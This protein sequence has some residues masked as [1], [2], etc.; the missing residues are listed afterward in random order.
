MDDRFVEAVREVDED[1]TSDGLADILWLAAHMADKSRVPRVGRHAKAARRSAGRITTAPAV[2]PP[3]RKPGS[4]AHT[5]K[6][7]PPP[8]HKV[9]DV[10]L[11]R[12]DFRADRPAV[13]AR[14]PAVSAIPSELDICRA[15]TPLKR[16][17]PSRSHVEPDEES[18]A[19]WIAETGLWFPRTVPVTERW[20]DLV[21]VVD[22]SAS[23]PIW[24][25]IL[26]EF[27]ALLERTGSFRDVRV[28]HLDGDL[29]YGDTVSVAMA[30]GGTG[31][32][33]DPAELVDPTSRRIILIASDC[34]GDAW[35][36]PSMADALDL[37][38]ASGPTA[39]VHMLPQRLWDD[40]LP[41]VHAVRMCARA[42]GVPNDQLLVEHR[43]HDEDT[44]RGTPIPVLELEERW[45]RPWA[46]LVGGPFGS[47]VNGCALFTG[48]LRS[49]AGRRRHL[50]Q[51]PPAALD[52]VEHL[53]RFRAQASPTAYRLAMSLAAGAPLTLRVMRLV[54]AAMLPSSRPSHLAEVFLGGLLRRAADTDGHPDDVEYEF[55][56]GIRDELI[57][58]LPRHHALRVLSTVSKFV[59][60]RWGSPFDFQAILTSSETPDLANISPRFAQVAFAVLTA[61]GGRFAEAAA[62]LSVA[63]SGSGGRG[64]PHPP[65]SQGKLR[66]HD[67]QSDEPGDDEVNS[68]SPTAAVSRARGSLLPKIMRGVPGRNPRFTGRDELIDRIRHMLISGTERAALLPHTLHGLGGVGKTQLA[69][70]YVYRFADDYDLICWLPAHDLTQ[71]RAS[72]VE[73]GSAMG[74]PDNPNVARAVAATLDALRA[75]QVYPKWLLVYDNA[76]R[77][78]DLQP[79]LPYPNGHVL[80]TSRNAGWSEIANAFEISVFTRN[81]SKALLRRRVPTMSDENADRLADRLGDLPLAIDQAGAWQAATGM[82]TDEYLRLFEDQFERLTEH[83]PSDYPTP[84]G[85]TYAVS[86][87][88][89]QQ[90]DPGAVQLLRVCAFFGAEPISVNLLR[91]GAQAVLPAPLAETLS[92]E[93]LLGKA[94]RE[95]GRYALARVDAVKNTITVHRLV[96]VVL[97]SQLDDDEREQT[98]I[99]AQH[100]LAAANPKNP[101]DQK[102]WPRHAELSPHIVP[103]NL[104]EAEED[105]TRQVVLDQVRYRWSR[106]DY[107]GSQELGEVTV[108]RWR[109]LWGENDRLTLIACRHLAVTRRTL[110]YYDDAR[111]LAEDTLARFRRELGDDNLHTLFTADSVAWDRRI[112]GRYQEAKELDEDN[113]RRLQSEFGEDHPMT[114]KAMNNYAIDLRCLGEFSRAREV[115]EQSLRLRRVVYGEEDRNTQLAVASLARDHY[116]LGDYQQGLELQEKALA[117]QRWLLG[118]TH[119][120]V[121]SQTRNLVI[122]LRKVGQYVRAREAAEELVNTYE[123]R[124]GPNDE[125]TLAAKTSYVNA[126]RMSGELE[127]ALQVG[128]DVLDR[129]RASFGPEHPSTLACAT[130]VAIVLLHRDLPDEALALNTTTLA[131][132]QRVLGENHPFVLSCASNTASDLASLGRH[133]EA[134]AMSEDTLLRASQVRGPDHPYTFACALNVA[135]DRRATGDQDGVEPLLSE[136]IAGLRRRLGDDHPETL[137]AVNGRRA[138]CDIEPHET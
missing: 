62:H 98:R 55:H 111:T 90:A 108:A 15:L 93:I 73:L 123:Q 42:P 45:L 100:I 94:L 137:A 88:R 20:F 85:A 83:P 30:P 134:R 64:S 71:V 87:N 11:P 122:L 48:T 60:Q 70:E 106:G 41:E 32:R 109:L 121:L 35:G 125:P 92:D 126:L 40:L 13:V 101:D 37:W 54:Q 47:W 5:R 74:L 27:R 1:V 131:A 14:S 58:E 116:Q 89:L 138:D 44:A 124:F 36:H 130:D 10:R 2:T 50:V 97:R 65:G 56:P 7:E 81:E 110:G 28:W 128:R 17:A 49:S 18:T 21:L 34:V 66:D 72:L 46:T 9:A 95:I 39:V 22:E 96:Q 78:E 136:T 77:P 80:V 104:I 105:R 6:E 68:A 118:E 135:L 25:R 119:G 133:S 24:Q 84:V 107:E 99:A 4:S 8:P 112:S 82:R 26:V 38:A 23:M 29:A 129:Y 115:D 19:E 127:K 91:D 117:I 33:R 57:S 113:F 76:D 52:P 51:E 103:A 59:S 12:P 63:H 67:R 69:I 31:S 120:Q 61:L 102:N 53:H 79:Y 75:G 132:M 3:V 86:L 43:T 16:R 114:L